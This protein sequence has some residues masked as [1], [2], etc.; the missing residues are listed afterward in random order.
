VKLVHTVGF[1][2]GSINI[3]RNGHYYLTRTV[4][5]TVGWYCN[6]QKEGS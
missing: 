1:S 5:H 3:A 2:L 6:A 4:P